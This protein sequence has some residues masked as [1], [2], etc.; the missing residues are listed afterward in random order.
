MLTFY[1]YH[2]I[3]R[4]HDITSNSNVVSVLRISELQTTNQEMEW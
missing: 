2:L 4:N 1:A 3:L